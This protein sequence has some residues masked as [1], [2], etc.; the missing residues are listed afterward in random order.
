MF[1]LIRYTCTFKYKL[2]YHTIIFPLLDF[3]FIINKLCNMMMMTYR[4]I[5]THS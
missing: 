2:R 4:S 1:N 5:K 3:S